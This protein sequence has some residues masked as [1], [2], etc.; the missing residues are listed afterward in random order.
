MPGNISSFDTTI[1][2]GKTF[3]LNVDEKELFTYVWKNGNDTLLNQ[4]IYNISNDDADISVTPNNYNNIYTLSVTDPSCDSYYEVIASI[5]VDFIDP[6]LDL[7]SVNDYENYPVILS[8]ETIELYSQNSSVVEYS[9]IWN[10][11]T[12]SNTSGLIT[13]NNLQQSDW[14]YLYVEDSEGCLGY[15]SI[16]VVVGVLPYDAITPNND[17]LNDFWTPKDI[18]SYPDALV[19]VFNRWGSLVFESRGGEN[20]IAW[21]GTNNGEQLN[22]GTYYYIIDLNTGDS[23]QSGPVTIIR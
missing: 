18:K 7:N 11:D 13:I 5:S 16:Y 20:Y 1:C 4:T 17:G 10:N 9:W 2:L 12:V 22:V 15:D 23:P 8:G 19:Q 21:D 3:Q 6:M 14:Y